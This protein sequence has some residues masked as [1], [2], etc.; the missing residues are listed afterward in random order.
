MGKRKTGKREPNGRLQRPTLAQLKQME[1]ERYRENMQQVSQQPHRRGFANP[2]DPRL[3]SPLGRFCAFHKLRDELCDAGHEW[4]E[5]RRSWNAAKGV[6]DPVHTGG[7]GSGQGPSPA[8]VD[9]WKRILDQIDEELYEANKATMWATRRLCIDRHFP[10]PEY[11]RFLINGL[12]IVARVLGRVE[13]N[14]HPFVRAA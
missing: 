1:A 2:I 13:S 14:V 9:R 3:E 8:T 5:M 12:S 6:P 7:M 10:G 11:V 4:A